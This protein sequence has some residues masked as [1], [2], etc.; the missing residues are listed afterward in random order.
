MNVTRPYSFDQVSTADLADQLRQIKERIQLL[1]QVYATTL[2]TEISQQIEEWRAEFKAR[3]DALLDREGGPDLVYELVRGD[4]DFFL[5]P[6]KPA[7]KPS[8]PV[9]VQHMAELVWSVNQQPPPASTKSDA[10]IDFG[11]GWMLR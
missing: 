8:I 6:P 5:T 4:E 7:A 1:R 9:A 11:L 2:S 10:S 3:A